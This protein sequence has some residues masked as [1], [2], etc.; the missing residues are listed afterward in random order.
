MDL[1]T[2]EF[3]GLDAGKEDYII[4]KTVWNA[5]GEAGSACGSTIPAAYG[6]RPFNI[7]TEKHQWTAS[8]RSFWAL[9]LGPVFLAR[10]FKKEKYYKHFVELVKLLH[11]CLQFEYS[12]DDIRTLRE[13]FIKW[14]EDYERYVFL[15][16]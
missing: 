15:S 13:G 3:K 14:V 12:S 2:G 10:R 11:I 5:I 9:Y 6:S 8:S 16:S 7:V 1:W 4:D